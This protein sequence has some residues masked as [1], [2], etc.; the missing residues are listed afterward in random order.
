MYF[1]NFFK[2][3]TWE[4]LHRKIMNDH[5]LFFFFNS[6]FNFFHLSRFLKNSTSSILK[7]KELRLVLVRREYFLSIL[8]M[9]NAAQVL[10]L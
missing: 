10:S 8:T 2:R 5:F 3:L 1:E 4:I 9:T 6:K 7:K